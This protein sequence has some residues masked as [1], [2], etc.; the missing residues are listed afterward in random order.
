MSSTTSPTNTSKFN[1]SIILVLEPT[2]DTFSTKRI[3]LSDN[4]PVKIGRI[5][6]KNTHQTQTNGYFDSRVLSRTHAEIWNDNGK[7]FV[8]DL[9]SSNGTFVNGKR[10]SVEDKEGDPVE[11]KNFDLLEFGIDIYNEHDRKLM[12]KKIAA[13]VQIIS[14]SN[15]RSR[16]SVIKNG[17]S[18]CKRRSGVH[19]PDDSIYASLEF[20][21]HNA[22]DEN[23]RLIELN[24]VLNDVGNTL[25]SRNN[26]DQLDEN[27][28]VHQ[29]FKEPQTKFRTHILN[30]DFE[31]DAAVAELNR[32]LEHEICLRNEYKEKSKMYEK[33]IQ[34]LEENLKTTWPKDPESDSK[35]IEELKERLNEL[36]SKFENLRLLHASEVEKLRE[37]AISEVEKLKEN[38]IS[39]VEKLRLFNVSEVGLQSIPIPYYTI[40]IL[41][42]YYT[43]IVYYRVCI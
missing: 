19:S 40:G 29:N 43:A 11:L 34:Q 37:N 28:V 9:K 42:L 2:N 27:V 22:R 41:I 8:R 4:T 36:A 7:V 20:E 16:M 18:S 12:F 25:G 15:A 38:A 39:E 30:R 5:T 17:Q 31:K 3:C 24:N 13:T 1:D 10:I 26:K 6:N 21:L 23:R 33:K 14:S 35:Q 32:K